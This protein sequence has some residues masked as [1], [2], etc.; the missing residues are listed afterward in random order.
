[1]HVHSLSYVGIV[2][3]LYLN[4]HGLPPTKGQGSVRLL[5]H[6]DLYLVIRVE[7]VSGAVVEVLKSCQPG[8]VLALQHWSDD[9]LT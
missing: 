9:I 8:H 6:L 4:D 5:S 7:H 2:P 3:L 1:M